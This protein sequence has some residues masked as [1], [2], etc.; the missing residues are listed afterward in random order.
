MNRSTLLPT[1]IPPARYLVNRSALRLG[2]LLIT[3][4][5][6]CFGFSL[7]IRAVTPAPD[8]GYPN[9]NT[10]EGNNAL[11][12][13]TTGSGNTAIGF[14]ALFFDTTGGFNTATGVQALASNI[15]GDQ[16]TAN[17]W[18]ALLSNTTGSVNTASGAATLN[19]NTTGRGNT[20]TGAFALEV[21]TA[22]SNNTATGAAALNG[23]TT[24]NS[25]TASGANALESNATGFDNTATGA[26]ALRFNTGSSNIAL[27]TN[28]GIKLTTGDYNI[29]I[30][31]HGVAGEGNTIRIGR[32]GFQKATYIAGI[33]GT[34]VAGGVGV[35]ADSHGHL[36][37]IL[38]SARYKEAI[39]PMDKAS[40]AIL[41]LEPVSFR[42]K[43]EIDPNGIPQFGLIAEE[44]EKVN[45]DLVVRDE[46]GK[47]MTV[48]YE[49]VNAMLLNEFL[50][51]HRKVEG[52]EATI[53]QVKSTL[54]QQ[55]KEFRA[56]I[57]RQ[58]KEIEALTTSLQKVR[59]QL[60]L[61]KP[62]PHLVADD[63]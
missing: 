32:A 56:T 38:S 16:N 23:N 10:A 12:N 8:G 57:E 28:A 22:G 43:E 53:S 55:Q 51:E 1:T 29:D 26:Q 3:L 47:V 2:P 20:A 31:A 18:G 25:N 46:D 15:T 24:G 50:K 30:G 58:Q 9:D 13:L 14:N 42:Y 34:V 36:G 45:S 52:Q 7:T 40:E 4:A 17:G 37:T 61:S 6:V 39:K 11:K 19:A 21:N 62:A 5:L 27:G 54:A 33:Y 48:R 59:D 41:Q 49:A 35:I 63:Q 60:E 44:V